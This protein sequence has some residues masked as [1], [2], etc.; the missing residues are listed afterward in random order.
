VF[1]FYYNY[2][3]QKKKKNFTIDG[4]FFFLLLILILELYLF[5]ILS[6]QSMLLSIYVIRFV[7][8]CML[9][10]MQSIYEYFVCKLDIN[11]IKKKINLLMEKIKRKETRFF[12]KNRDFNFY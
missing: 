1:F 2:K 11:F 5:A 4:T 7:F 3:Y 9:L 8:I 12:K 6:S 10:C